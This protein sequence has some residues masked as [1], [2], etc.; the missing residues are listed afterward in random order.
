MILLSSEFEQNL[1]KYAEVIV[2]VG[3]NL[4]AGQRLL[5]GAPTA[6]RY[7]IPLEL[8]PLIRLVTKKA[9]QA[10]AK[11]VDVFWDDD[12]IRLIRYQNAPRN[13]FDEYPTWRAEAGLSIAKETDAMLIFPILDPD[14]LLEQDP[15]LILTTRKASLK[16]NRPSNDLRR[17]GMVNWTAVAAP[18]DGWAD[19]VLPMVPQEERKSKLWDMIFDICRIKHK[20]P[21]S[22]WQ[23]HINQLTVRSS[24][25][26]KKRYHSLRFHSLKT[27]L[28]IGLPKKHIWRNAYFTTQGGISNLVNIPT[29]EIFTTPHKDKTEGIVTATKP[30]V[31]DVLIEDLSLTFSKGKI[32]K[33]SAKTGEKFLQK[34]LKTD[35]GASRL[36]EV[37]LV[38]HSSPI[39]QAGVLFYNILIDENASCHIALGNGL[40]SAIENG[41]T[42]SDEEFSSAGG[43]KCLFHLDFMLGSE[44]MDVEGIKEDGNVERI[45]SKGEWSF[46]M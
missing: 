5:I 15:D 18:I 19:K 40:R 35:E 43:N 28:T 46:Q 11:L 26:N 22:K 30:I 3:L 42:M 34:L 17:K 41:E 8:A 23:E 32:I 39:S 12:Q 37:S 45:M 13:S 33:A 16:Q 24:Y 4:Q 36:G 21:I 1:E 6:A 20:D 25:L 7:G 2:K 10:G 38:P 14:L 31:T 27:D 44:E 29:E 9:Y